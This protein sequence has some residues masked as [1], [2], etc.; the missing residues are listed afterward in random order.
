MDLLALIILIEIATSINFEFDTKQDENNFKLIVSTGF[1]PENMGNI[2]EVIALD[3]PSNT[4]ANLPDLPTELYDA[5]GAMIDSNF[6]ICGGKDVKHVRRRECY[7]FGS[8]GIWTQGP[9]LTRAKM[10][11]R[12]TLVSE[13]NTLIIFGGTTDDEVSN[14]IEEVDFENQTSKVI[15]HLPFGFMS[16]CLINQNGLIYVIGGSQGSNFGTIETWTSKMD[17]FDWIQG[18]DLNQPRAIQACTHIPKWDIGFVTGGY[19]GGGL[20]STEILNNQ[21]FTFGKFMGY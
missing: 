10:N 18:P 9:N 4:C 5:Q 13:R 17:D 16:G 11:S 8:N 7:I 2:S 15:G 14:E 19:Y 3:N 1:R 12:A 6:V 21:L 20:K